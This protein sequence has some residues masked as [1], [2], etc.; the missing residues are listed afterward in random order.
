M[1]RIHRKEI[2]CILYYFLFN[3]LLSHLPDFFTISLCKVS[4]NKYYA[5]VPLSGLYMYVLGKLLYSLWSSNF[6]L[7]LAS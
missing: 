6:I 3:F 4:I 1:D 7:R 2:E 5:N